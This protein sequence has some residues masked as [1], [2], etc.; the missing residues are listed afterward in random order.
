MTASMQ[1]VGTPMALPSSD[2]GTR[3]IGTS[4]VTYLAWMVFGAMISL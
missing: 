2:M 3:L 1:G 4:S